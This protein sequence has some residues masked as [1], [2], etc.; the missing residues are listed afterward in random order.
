[1]REC[2]VLVFAILRLMPYVLQRGA[3][4]DGKLYFFF[5]F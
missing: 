2:L 5:F 3:D 1:M 4:R